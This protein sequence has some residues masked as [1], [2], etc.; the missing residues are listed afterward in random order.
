MS[1]ENEQ[2]HYVIFAEKVDGKIVW[3]IDLETSLL[4][5]GSIFDPDAPWGAAWRCVG[6][7]DRSLDDEFFTDLRTRLNVNEWGRPALPYY[8]DDVIAIPKES[9]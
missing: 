2:Y 5:D 9:K 3:H 7:D 6:D 1:K 4:D 8:P